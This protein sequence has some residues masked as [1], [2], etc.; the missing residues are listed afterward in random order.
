[1][2]HGVLESEDILTLKGCKPKGMELKRPPKE[3]QYERKRE[4]RENRQMCAL[5]KVARRE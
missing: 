3:R 4:T 2:H 1:M 5:K